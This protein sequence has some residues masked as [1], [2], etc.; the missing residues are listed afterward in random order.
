MARRECAERQGEHRNIQKEHSESNWQLGL[1][2][3]LM[4]FEI[5]KQLLEEILVHV[6]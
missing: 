4:G 6:K 1:Q 5:P 3:F 2:R